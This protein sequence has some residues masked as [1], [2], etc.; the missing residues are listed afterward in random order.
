MCGS[1]AIMV[2]REC[3]GYT[4][5]GRRI[6]TIHFDTVLMSNRQTDGRTDG[7]ISLD[8][9]DQ[10]IGIPSRRTKQFIYGEILYIIGLVPQLG[11]L[12][13]LLAVNGLVDILQWILSMHCNRKRYQALLF[14]PVLI[15][16]A[17]S[18]GHCSWITLRLMLLLCPNVMQR[19]PI[20]PD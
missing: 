6:L 2:K 17:N 5:W 18:R 7:R 16:C 20:P 9:I 12:T 11:L 1:T 3:H 8:T 15:F 19:Y 13:F 14:A 4:R 10:G